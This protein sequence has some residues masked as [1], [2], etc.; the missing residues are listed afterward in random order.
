VRRRFLVV[1]G[2]ELRL[3]IL[4]ALAAHPRCREAIH[5]H[6]AVIDNYSLALAHVYTSLYTGSSAYVSISSGSSS[7]STLRLLTCPARRSRILVSASS[8]LAASTLHSI[9][10]W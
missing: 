10:T 1:R 2:M 8:K 3:S 5:A 6:A 4:E 7:T 9:C